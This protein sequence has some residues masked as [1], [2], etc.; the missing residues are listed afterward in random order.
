MWNLISNHPRKEITEINPN[1][2]KI[3][4][5]YRFP[6][7]SWLLGIGGS[8]LSHDHASIF[9]TNVTQTWPKVK[10]Y[11]NA[12]LVSSSFFISFGYL[13]WGFHMFLT[14][15]DMGMGNWQYF[16]LQH[17]SCVCTTP[18]LSYLGK[19]TLVSIWF[20][21]VLIQIMT[22]VYKILSS[23]H[24]HPIYQKFDWFDKYNTHR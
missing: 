14:D 16:G 21:M 4:T 9:F 10:V 22:W 1:L 24:T 18:K 19:I 12:K 15:M 11:T 20:R 2:I 5:S 3:L 7:G 17:H 23:W 13:Y 6:M 8:T